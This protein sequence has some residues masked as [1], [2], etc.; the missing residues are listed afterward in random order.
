MCIKINTLY[1][2]SDWAFSLVYFKSV[3]EKNFKPTVCV[4][5]RL[6]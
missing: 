4:R 2:L 5:Y 3:T 6:T 1:I